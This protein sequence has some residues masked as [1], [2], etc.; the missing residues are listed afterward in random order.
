MWARLP[1]VVGFPIF[2]LQRE[3]DLLIWVRFIGVRLEFMKEG[4]HRR[5]KTA[6]WSEL[7]R[8]HYPSRILTPTKFRLLTEE[9]GLRGKAREKNFARNK[10]TAW[11]DLDC[12]LCIRLSSEIFL[13]WKMLTF[14]VNIFNEITHTQVNQWVISNLIRQ[15]KSARDSTW[16]QKKSKSSIRVQNREFLKKK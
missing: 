10:T 13:F 1:R 14:F 15:Q 4:Q 9:V 5:N 2:Y 12:R 16:T 6:D 3:S 8:I 11:V 7:S